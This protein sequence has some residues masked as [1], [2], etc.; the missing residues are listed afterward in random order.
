VVTSGARKYASHSAIRAPFG[1][2]IGTPRS[3]PP[4]TN[5]PSE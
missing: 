1:P 5:K 2:S 3:R 4:S